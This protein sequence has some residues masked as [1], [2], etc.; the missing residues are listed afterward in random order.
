MNQVKGFL[1]EDLD[2]C[3][4]VKDATAGHVL[5]SFHRN[6]DGY[7]TGKICVVYSDGSHKAIEPEEAQ[8]NIETGKW[9]VYRPSEVVEMGRPTWE[10]GYCDHP[11]RRF[12][13]EEVEL[14]GNKFIFSDVTLDGSILLELP[15]VYE[16]RMAAVEK[17]RKE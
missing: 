9:T 3:E 16:E 8:I 6:F 2:G 15:P 4:F 12:N 14:L 13:G 11:W 7:E 1:I 17:G 10:D 5:I